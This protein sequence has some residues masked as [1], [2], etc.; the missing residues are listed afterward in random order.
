M[1]KAAVN[2]DQFAQYK[3]GKSAPKPAYENV[4]KAYENVARAL[5]LKSSLCFHFVAWE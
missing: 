4:A 5:S 1:R 2:S 3:E